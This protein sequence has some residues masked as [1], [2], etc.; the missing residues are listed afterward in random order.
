[1]GGAAGT[2]GMPTGGT[3]GIGGMLP[4]GPE[5]GLVI[6]GVLNS[7]QVLM[8]VNPET[9]EE[10]NNEP[11]N[12][13]AIAHDPFADVWYIWERT[14]GVFDD[15]T[16]HIRRLTYATGVWEEIATLAVPAID[17]HD[18]AAVLNQRILYTHAD[19][20]T[21]TQIVLLNTSDPLNVTVL[22]DANPLP[23]EGSGMKITSGLIA[24]P[25]E[26]AVGGLVNLVRIQ[27]DSCAPA[28]GPDG[29]VGLDECP[30]NLVRADVREA[31]V[32]PLMEAEPGVQ[33]GTV[34]QSGGSLA[35]ASDRSGNR[36]ILVFPPV[37]FMAAGSMGRTQKY[38][39][40]A[41]TPSGPEVS[42]PVNGPR[43]SWADWDPCN[44]ILLAVELKEDK[45]AFA[46]PL[47]PAGTP[48][49]RDLVLDE[50]Q[51]VYF[52]PWSRIALYPLAG[53]VFDIDA[54]VLEGDRLAPTLTRLPTWSPPPINPEA[55]A[56]RNYVTP[57][58]N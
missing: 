9:G 35:F 37:D 12:V 58:C 46:V 2:A 28:A 53:L 38:Q 25:N 19:G 4:T 16:L 32:A 31:D 48:I 18:R 54:L 56:V 41:H 3:A 10:F 14:D 26:Q 30:V 29:G 11:M 7:E 36:D 15:Q 52:E 44:E 22:S 13:K 27:F 34:A 43:F 33:V 55:V 50:G 5:G 39:T 24:H 17:G 51:K 6:G 40:Q 42:F 45:G 8:T 57:P 23:D 49:R 20:P 1:M 47:D 21:L